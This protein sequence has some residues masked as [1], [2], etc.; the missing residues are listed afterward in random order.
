MK[1]SSKPAYLP[2]LRFHWLTPYYD[3]IVR[4]TTRERSFKETLIAQADIKESFDVLDLGC[5]TG[6][7]AI[8]VKQSQPLSQVMAVDGD[9]KILCIAED[10]ARNNTVQINFD[11]ALSNQLPYEDDCFD[12]VLSSLFFH[13][14]NWENKQATANE[15]FRTL[16]PGAELHIADWGKASNIVARGLFLSI[17]MLDGFTTTKANVQGR[18]IELFELAGFENVQQTKRFNTFFGTMCLYKATK[19]TV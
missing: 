10:K 4:L 8:M 3:F 5:G 18:L 11:H 17:Q 6:T 19:P 15:M 7:L 14:L 13:H 2:A 1:Q 16:K 9:K 12:V